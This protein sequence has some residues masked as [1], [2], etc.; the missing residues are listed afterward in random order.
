[1][2][3]PTSRSQ[4]FQGIMSWSVRMRRVLVAQKQLAENNSSMGPRV[5]D[6]ERQPPHTEGLISL[7]FC[8]VTTLHFNSAI[9]QDNLDTSGR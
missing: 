5:Y 7:T 6:G 3:I 1:M 4:V 2:I 9:P 8:S